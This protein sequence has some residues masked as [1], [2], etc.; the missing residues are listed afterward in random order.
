M[1]THK[2]ILGIVFIVTGTIQ[3][4]IFGIASLIFATLLP[5]IIEEAGDGAWALEWLLD[6]GQI[7]ASFIIFVFCIPSIIAGI[8][9][10][11]NKRWAM[12]LALIVGCFKLFSFP[13][14]TIIGVYTIWVYS[15]DQKQIKT[16]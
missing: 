9:L 14:G 10:V 8:G 16:N 7:I 11:T 1:E 6:Y 15:E 13:I 3:V 2:R 4:L 12:L 5:M